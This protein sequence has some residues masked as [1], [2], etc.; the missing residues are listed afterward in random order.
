[1]TME[2]HEWKTAIREEMGAF[3]KNNTW[4]LCALP[5]RHK[6]VGCWWIFTLK[7]KSVGTLD[8][9]KARLGL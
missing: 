6:I 9:Y 1:M 5:I 3:K 2:I 8:S 7:Y 4:N